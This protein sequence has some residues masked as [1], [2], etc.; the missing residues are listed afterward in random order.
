MSLLLLRSSIWCPAA[1]LS[2]HETQ[3]GEFMFGLTLRPLAAS[4]LDR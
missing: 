2:R 1:G 3:S 4:R